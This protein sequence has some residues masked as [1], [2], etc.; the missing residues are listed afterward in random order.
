MST[1][2]KKNSWIA[3]LA[4]LLFISALAGFVMA[5]LIH[6]TNDRFFYK[7]MVYDFLE[8]AQKASDQRDECYRIFAPSIYKELY[9]GDDE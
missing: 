4:F 3:S 2:K 8:V 6:L 5:H 1:E 7:M 9:E